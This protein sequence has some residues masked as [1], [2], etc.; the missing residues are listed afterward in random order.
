M[1]LNNFW[2]IFLYKFKLNLN[3]AKTAR[4]INQAFGNDS[5]NER[6][7]GR[8]FAK[9]RS[10]DFSLEVEPQSAQPRVIQD[11]DLRTLME[12][13]PSEISSNLSSYTSLAFSSV[14]FAN[15]D[16]AKTTFV[17]FVESRAPNCYADGINLLLS[18]WQKCTGSNDDYLN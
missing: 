2:L 8:W 9:F 6:T 15:Q 5:V 10:R 18:L 17:D 16:Q 12:T 11:E 13:D 3:A 14:T 7:V 1:S 4:K